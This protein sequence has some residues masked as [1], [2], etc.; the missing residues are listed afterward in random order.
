MGLLTL[1]SGD[2]FRY[3]ISQGT[4][5]GKKAQ[6]Y[7]LNGQL[8]PDEVTI[9]M[10]RSRLETDN[11]R[12]NG[13]VLD[14]YPRSVAQAQ[15]LD[16]LLEELNKKLDR[17]VSLELDD[18]VIVGRLSGRRIC[19]N[20]GDL[21][22]LVSRPSKKEGA[23]NK[24]GG[25]LVI[26]KDDNPDTIRQRLLVFHKTTEP[27]LNYYQGKGEVVKIDGALSTEQVYSQ[28]TEGLSA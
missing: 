8:V 18:E 2:I 12:Q 20:C 13:F 10:M 16:R 6:E 21:Y 22:H 14:G 4:E 28:I 19:E 25:R 9:E 1:A 7:I 5:L 11:A 23:C 27:V 24:C 15:A 26:R 17:V 3:E